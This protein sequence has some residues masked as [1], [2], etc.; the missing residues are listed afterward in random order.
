MVRNSSPYIHLYLRRPATSKHL[1]ASTSRCSTTA[2]TI[3]REGFCN[4]DAD[5]S[6][7]CETSTTRHGD[8]GAATLPTPCLPNCYSAEC[9]R[10]D[11]RASRLSCLRP[12]EHD[13]NLHCSREHQS[14]SLNVPSDLQPLSPFILFPSDTP[15]KLTERYS[16]VLTVS[17]RGL[18][19][20][21]R[22]CVA[23][24]RI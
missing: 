18:S 8:V 2:T 19:A 1:H 21:S 3:P 11:R 5:N 10:Q 15:Y 20:C 14:D 6:N 9:I 17:M 24:S 7:S 12:E 4:S 13:E 23:L 22:V 16:D